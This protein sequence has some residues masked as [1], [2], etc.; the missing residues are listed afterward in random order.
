MPRCP[1]C[2]KVFSENYSFCEECGVKLLETEIH[3]LESKHA[4]DRI[5]RSVLFRITR[6]YTWTILILAILGFVAAIVIQMSD[7]SSLISRD[8]GVSADEIK[9]FLAAKKAGK[10]PLEAEESTKAIDP[11]LLSKLDKEIYELIALLPKKTQ[12]EAGVERLRGDIKHRIDHYNT[13][14]EM[15]KVLREAKKVLLKFSEPERPQALGTFFQM[16]SQKESALAMG[17][18]KAEAGLLKIGGVFFALIMTIAAFSLILV[19]LAIER[20]TRRQ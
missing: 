7:I 20:N 8:T 17:R 2:K 13:I 1:K 9:T 15:M 14:K 5:E 19:L 4:F 11:D 12:D 3:V 16:K 18:A 6:S 10:N